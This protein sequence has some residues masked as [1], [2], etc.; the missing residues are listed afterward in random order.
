MLQLHV[1]PAHAGMRA[2]LHMGMVLPIICRTMKPRPVPARIWSSLS[3]HTHH[4]IIRS[5]QSQA[6]SSCAQH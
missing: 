2:M 3:L 5:V 1:G 4:L 6:V